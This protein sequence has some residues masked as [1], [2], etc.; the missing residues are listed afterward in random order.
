MGISNP[1]VNAL[2]DSRSDS[3]APE[4]GPPPLPDCVTNPTIR[5]PEDVVAWFRDMADAGLFF[6]PESSFAEYDI[7]PA[8][9]RQMDAAMTRAYRYF[10][11][12]CV[13]AIA[14]D[15]RCPSRVQA[16]GQS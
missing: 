1:A 4:G 13:V 8:D 11:D 6:H 10:R 2:A 15:P 12:P 9:A 3:L 7:P 5:Q 16:L 14:V